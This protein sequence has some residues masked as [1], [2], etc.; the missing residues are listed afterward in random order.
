MTALR[1]SPVEE[2]TPGRKL[3]PTKPTS[4]LDTLYLAI[5]TELTDAKS[6]GGSF[7][8]TIAG[9]CNDD[10]NHVETGD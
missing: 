5:L 4:S 6:E 8:W 1:L 10:P 7:K 3:H 2:L 9:E